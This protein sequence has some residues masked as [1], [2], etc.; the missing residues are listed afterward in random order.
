MKALIAVLMSLGLGIGVATA[1][2]PDICA[3]PA[4]LLFGDYN[5]TKVSAAV[6]DTR[7]LDVL[8]I[9]TGSSILAGNDAY[10]ARLEQALAKR[11]PGIAVKVTTVAKTRQ[12]AEEMAKGL[13][14]ILGDVKPSLV[15]WQTGTVDAMRGVDPESFRATLEKG[16][17]VLQARGTD[18]VLMNMQY[19]P[20]TETMIALGSFVDNMRWVSQ[21]RD[22]PLFDRLAIMRHWSESGSFDM[23]A[24][25]KD[26]AMAGKVHECIGRALAALV[27]E[28]AHL[29]SLDNRAAQ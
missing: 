6:R 26:P 27:I 13:D 2:A 12:T 15:I 4:Y 20:R 21:Q 23:Y 16:L 25:T 22:V 3:V 9:G 19:S 5:L 8:V 29:G 11:L 1:Q 14:K 28:A 10:P 7:R 18:V 17:E 24:T